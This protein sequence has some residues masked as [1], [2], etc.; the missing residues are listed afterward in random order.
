MR[1]QDE[2][3]KA[4]QEVLEKQI[5]TKSPKMVDYCMKK[6]AYIVELSDG[7]FAEIDKPTI[8]TDF[9]FGYG[10]YGVSTDEDYDRA[11]SMERHARTNESYFV[12]ENLKGIDRM[13]EQFQD[14]GMKA[15]KR[16]HYI[17]QTEGSPLKSIEFCRYWETPE[18]VMDWW[19]KDKQ[20][21]EETAITELL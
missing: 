17:G 11:A 13:I 21:A 9:C 12:Q 4:M 18:K 7:D 1:N 19:L 20:T 16:L 6:A 10:M 2:L 14:D 5:W 15:Y 8:E 3:K